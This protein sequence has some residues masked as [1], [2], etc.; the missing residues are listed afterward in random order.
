MIILDKD[1]ILNEYFLNGYL[2]VIKRLLTT[3]KDSKNQKLYEFD[4]QDIIQKLINDFL[5][6]FEKDEKGNLIVIDK[7]C[8]YSKYSEYEYVSN[9]YQIL[10]LIISL[11]PEKYL[12]LFFENEEIKNVREKHLS[13]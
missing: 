2:R 7:L 12:K 6:T 1:I 10:N 8:K 11:N 9:I 13:K 3:L 5:I 4:F